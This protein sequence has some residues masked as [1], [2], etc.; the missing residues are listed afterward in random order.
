LFKLKKKYLTQHLLFL[1][2]KDKLKIYCLESDDSKLASLAWY[3]R[4]NGSMTSDCTSLAV[5]FTNGR[6]QLMKNETDDSNLPLKL[7]SYH[8]TIK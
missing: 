7:N 8:K 3:D 4:S 5:C 2:L 1:I 6:C